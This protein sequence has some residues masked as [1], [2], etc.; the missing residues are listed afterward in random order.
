MTKESALIGHGPRWAALARAF[1]KG[2]VPQTLLISGAPQSG[3]WTFA[4]RYAQLLLCPNVK[5]DEQGLPAPCYHCR[6]CHQIE[7]ETFPDFVVMRPAVAA[8]KDSPTAPEAL[9]SSVIV[10]EMARD[11]S[12]E[13]ARNPLVGKRKVM[14][15]NQAE[16]MTHPAQ[17]SL[18]KTLEEPGR[19]YTMLLL[20]SNPDQLLTTIISR[21]WHLPLGL[22]ADAEITHW[23]GAQ[24]SE[25]S[26]DLIDEAVRVAAG[27][28]GAAWR[29]L[30]RL[31][32][33]PA[34][35][36]A[37][38]KSARGQEAPAA[39]TD[40]ARSVQAA[41]IVERIRRSQPVGA[42]ALTEEALRLARLWWAED[43]LDEATTAS[44]KEI[45]ADA[46]V[47]RSGVARFLDELSTA[48]RTS[49]AAS[50]KRAAPDGAQAVPEASVWADGLDQIRK[51]RHYILR[52]AN[53]NLALDVMFGRLIA[54][55]GAPAKPLRTR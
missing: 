47:V 38:G 23:L 22:A 44:K 11:F 20:S 41:Q 18:L 17:N 15:I 30:R 29:E 16:R 28:P 39:E 48:Y 43:Q 51:T 1:A 45:K 8:A 34:S 25:A 49:W 33:A 9:D 13:A 3:K 27:R 46:K 19:G 53:T 31:Q 14:V 2:E 32:R 35:D 24:F 55:H 7:I 4:L 21:C 54:M 36:K 40:V 10:I 26:S 42:L 12:N 37:A 52:N 6:I 50:V 5:S